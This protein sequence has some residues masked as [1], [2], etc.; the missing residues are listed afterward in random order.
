MVRESS[1]VFLP[2]PHH[3]RAAHNLAPR[4]P[5]PV[6]VYPL[7]TATTFPTPSSPQHPRHHLPRGAEARGPTVNEPSQRPTP[8]HLQDLQSARLIR[9]YERPSFSLKIPKYDGHDVV[10]SLG[11]YG[12]EACQY[13]SCPVVGFEERNRKFLRE[14]AAANKARLAEEKRV[15]VYGS[16]RVTGGAPKPNTNQIIQEPHDDLY[17]RVPL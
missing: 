10:K 9:R 5:N 12:K 7:L 17:A 16:D 6:S 14:Q 11:D 15:F 8:L 3:I 13:D 4:A 1:A 2:S